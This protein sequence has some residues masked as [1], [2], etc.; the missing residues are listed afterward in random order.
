MTTVGCGGPEGVSLQSLDDQAAA[1]LVGEDTS[2]E[3]ELGKGVDDAQTRTFI[4]CVVF[5]SIDTKPASSF[6]GRLYHEYNVQTHQDIDDKL[7]I[8]AS[9]SAKGFWGSAR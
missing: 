8:S 3:P 4:K 5:P 2:N 9:L 6:R 7:G 1:A